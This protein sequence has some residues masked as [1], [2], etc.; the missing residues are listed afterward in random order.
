MAA[1]LEQ[2]PQYWGC[3]VFPRQRVE[4]LQERSGQ[5]D[6]EQVKRASAPMTEQVQPASMENREQ[7]EVSPVVE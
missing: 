6:P 3:C 4:M 5:V 1:V 7:Y 2:R